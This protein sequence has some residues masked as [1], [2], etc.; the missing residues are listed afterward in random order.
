MSDQ[1]TPEDW[2][3]WHSGQWGWWPTR[4]QWY[5]T[6]PPDPVSPPNP[7]E[8]VAA[9]PVPSTV[10]EGTKPPETPLVPQP[11]GYPPPKRAKTETKDEMEEIHEDE[12]PPNPSEPPPGFPQAVK[13][14]LPDDEHQLNQELAAAVAQHQQSILHNQPKVCFVKFFFVL[15]ILLLCPHLIYPL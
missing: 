4:E 11:P 12:G 13:E 3:L 6:Q 2:D 15:G 9:E 8:P 1:W 5:G 10:P 14:E 7:V